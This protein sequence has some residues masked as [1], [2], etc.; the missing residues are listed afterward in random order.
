ME[1]YAIGPEKFRQRMVESQVRA[2]GIVDERVLKAMLHVPR[3]LFTQEKDLAVAYG[4]Y[5]LSIGLNQ[6]ISQPYIVAF[7]TEALKLKGGERILEIGTGSGY[8]TAML[9]ELVDQVYTIEV[10]ETL[11]ERAKTTLSGMGYKNI[12]FKTGNGRLGWSEEAPFD[13]ILVT[14]APDM[15]PRMLIDQLVPGGR[16]VIPVGEGNQSL[17]RYERTESDFTSESLLAVRFVPLV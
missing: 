10:R 9:A 8:Q 2:R 14:A 1:G 5:P 12:F 6:T 17:M 13:G 15:L 16:M 4:D 7:M 11:S 3:H